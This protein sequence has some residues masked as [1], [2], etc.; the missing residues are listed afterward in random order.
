MSM[1]AKMWGSTCHGTLACGGSE[2]LIAEPY[3]SAYQL[4]F[5]GLDVLGDAKMVR[6]LGL[7]LIAVKPRKSASETHEASST[8]VTI[9]FHTHDIVDIYNRPQSRLHQRHKHLSHPSSSLLIRS[10]PSA[11]T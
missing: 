1:D 6:M 9:Q 11:S 2:S 4:L 3:L 8:I 7:F 10:F 5:F